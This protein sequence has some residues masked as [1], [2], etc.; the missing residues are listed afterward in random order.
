MSDVKTGAT[1]LV[2]RSLLQ[3]VNEKYRL[4][5]LMLEYLQMTVKKELGRKASSRQAHFLSRI[6]VLR[7]Y[8][9]GDQWSSSGD[10]YS[11]VA[12]WTAVKKLDR[13]LIVEELYRTSLKGVT[14]IEDMQNAGNLL[15]LLVSL[16]TTSFTFRT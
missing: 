4:H 13:S 3:V 5:D 1:F 6:E 8:S 9:I 7:R 15:R 11:L 10:P 16:Y 2:D 14:E 12:L